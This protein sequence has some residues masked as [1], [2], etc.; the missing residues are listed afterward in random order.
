MSTENKIEI[1]LCWFDREQWEQLALVDPEGVDNSYEEWKQ[2]AN[3]AVSNFI[4]NDQKLRKISINTAELVKWCQEK[5][6][7]PNSSARSEYAAMVAQKRND[8]KKT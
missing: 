8:N 5:D 6:Q 1:A 4:A 3:K 7:A 2:G